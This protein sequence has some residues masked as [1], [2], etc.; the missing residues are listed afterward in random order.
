M[1]V[2]DRKG[3]NARAVLIGMATDRRAL[4][5][6]AEK[7]D[8]K[9]FSSKAENLIGGWCVQHY[10]KYKKPPRRD[11]ESYFNNWATRH[12][13]DEETVKLVELFL[14]SLS[15][16]SV[17]GRKSVGSERLVEMAGEVFNLARLRSLR[18]ELD[19][20]IDAGDPEKGW[21]AV[22]DA[23]KV[24]IGKDGHV[25][26][27]SDS[28][29]LREAFETKDDVLVKF[30]QPCIDNF[31]ATI[32]SR[33]A[34]VSFQGPEKSGKSFLL[35]EIAW[36]GIRNKRNVAFFEVGDQTKSQ[37][38]RRF[39]VRA[40]GKPIRPERNLGVPVSMESGNPPDVRRD[41]RK[42]RRGLTYEEGKLALEAV[43]EEYGAD[44][45]R[46]SVH[47]NTS[48]SVGGVEAALEG[49]TRDNWSPDLVVVDYA[50]IL[51]PL[52]AKADTR[53]QINET[54]KALRRLNQRWDCLLVTATQSDANSYEKRLQDRSNFS[55]DKR[56]Y[57]HV[58]ACVAINQLATE[59][60]QGLLRLN[61]LEGRDLDF[62][63]R[64]CLWLAS[65][66]PLAN[67][68]VCSCL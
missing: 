67:P 56:K 16:E 63:T 7:W 62:S 42:F 55:E 14:Q 52:Q 65:C 2:R 45:L 30:G 26:V 10:R 3:D 48:I 37:I 61:I 28:D 58:T 29:D 31:F 46:L 54:W 43:A 35:Q 60:D 15:D 33:G 32:F 41:F 66:L 23:R 20:H 68:M 9:L 49:W 5:V 44:R 39:A 57:A 6:A 64:A 4:A 22:T 8:G 47:P 24:E 59:K 34:F 18:E 51:A 50:D 21:E 12:R 11:I 38:M 40:S 1:K 19:G 53:D 36:Q 13:R 17:S 27:L 25:K